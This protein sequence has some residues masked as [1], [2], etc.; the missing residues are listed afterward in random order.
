MVVVFDLDAAVHHLL[1]DLI[2]QIKMDVSR[3]IGMIALLR[4]SVIAV[5]TR[6]IG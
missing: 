3:L 4:Q 6:H 2:A 5:G 1:A